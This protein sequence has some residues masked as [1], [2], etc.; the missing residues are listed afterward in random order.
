MRHTRIELTSILPVNTFK[1]LN[2]FLKH[3]AQS[4]RDTIN[5]RHTKK[6][7]SLK[8][9][10]NKEM[11]ATKNT[12]VINLSKKPLTDAERSLLEKGAKIPYKNIIAEVETAIKDLPDETKDIIRT[13]TA[14]IL[15]RAHIPPH[16]NIN[17]NERK[18]LKDL[19]QDTT[20]II[21][22]ADKGNCLVIMNRDEYDKKMENLLKDEATYTVIPKSPFKQIERELNAMLLNLKNQK[23]IPENTYRNLHSSNA[24]PPAIR[25]SIKHHKVG[26]PLRPIVTC[27]DSALYET[28][29]FLKKILS[30]LQNR[31]G[32]SVAN[33]TQFKNEITT[34]P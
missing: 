29:K 34:S 15:D 21:M 24:I 26:Y 14:S 5:T 8:D 7:C 27:I 22:K 10:Y 31:N 13:N 3:R 9:E 23:K 20:R 28:S 18:V 32:F 25:G 2:E 1:N 6:Y 30:P 4:V 16:H 12:S 17:I 19:R 11:N 33:S